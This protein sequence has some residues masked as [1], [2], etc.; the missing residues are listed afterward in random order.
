[1]KTRI[2]YVYDCS[3]PLAS[4]RYYTG[5][6]DPNAGKLIEIVITVLDDD[7]KIVDR[8]YYKVVEEEKDD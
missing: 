8:R 4:S 5:R 2:G 7:N 3:S 1:M 6:F